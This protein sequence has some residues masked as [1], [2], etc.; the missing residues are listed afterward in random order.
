V[1]TLPLAIAAV[2]VLLSGC[3][4][5]R[6]LPSGAGEHPAGWADPQSAAF[7]GPWLHANGDSLDACRTC[8]GADYQ[9]GAVGVACTSQ[10]CHTQP[11]G[12]EFC[13]TCHGGAAG[14]LPSTGAHALHA[15][16]CNDCHQVPATV[17]APGHLGATARVAFSGLALANGAMPAWIPS[18]QRCSGVY[19]HEGQS[20]IWQAPA[21]AVRCDA[22]HATPPASH[23]L[24]SRVATAASCTTCHPVPPAATHVD[25]IVELASGVACDTCHGHGPQGAPAPGLDGSTD[26]TSRGVGA[27]QAHLD[28]AF[29]G[30]TGKVVDCATC[31]PVPASITTPGHLDHGAPATVTLPQGGAYDPGGQS[32]TVW[33][34]W[35]KSPGPVWTDASGG[36]LACNACHG[37]PPVLMRN[38]QIH[39]AAQPVLGACLTCHPFTPATHVDGIVELLP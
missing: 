33:C 20:P 34:H 7:H 39:T 8:H 18:Q 6:A 26:P 21:G 25:G 28:P 17:S 19:C 38:G 24:W 37:F 1:S 12:P 32:C 23:Q 5:V 22:C 31:H 35:N 16:F 9:G 15:A 30:R 36:A 2:A 11:G 10:G 14:P 29:P 13:G 4:V 3:T 27:H